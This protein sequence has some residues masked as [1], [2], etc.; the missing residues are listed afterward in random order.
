M[1]SIFDEDE[2]LLINTVKL[3]KLTDSELKVKH[4]KIK[5]KNEHQKQFT[6][7]IEDNQITICKGPAGTGKSFLS[8][9]KAFEII[10]DESQPQRKIFLI[11][12]AVEAEEKI[13]FLP[14]DMLEKL[15]PYLYSTYYIID[16]LIGTETRKKLIDN[17]TIEPIA[18]GF[19]RGV[20]IDNAVLIC[21]E[22]QNTSVTTMLTLLTRIGFNSKF[23]ISGDIEQ[24]DN[25][26]IRT[27]KES[28]LDYAYNN[29]GSIDGIG[30]FEFINED[31]IR[32]KLISKI[33]ERFKK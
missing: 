25:K 21:E 27:V 17:G 7:L 16:I 8:I 20:N 9:A 6:K 18:I 29:L 4:I 11:T 33:L 28:G 3:K 23:I 12:P 15:Y 2:E 14:G 1:K 31:I 26:A 22:A 13:G 30:R 19:L 5:H 32:N 10:Q 24:I